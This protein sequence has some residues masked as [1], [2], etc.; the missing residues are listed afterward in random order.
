M[1]VR[2]VSSD[3]VYCEGVISSRFHIFISFNKF[4]STMAVRIV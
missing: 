4:A 1:I 3:T 2:S